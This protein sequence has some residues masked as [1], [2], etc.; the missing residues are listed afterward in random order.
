MRRGAR[1][2]VLTVLTA[3]ALLGGCRR[4]AQPSELHATAQPPLWVISDA[5]GPRA[6]IFGT[7]HALPEGVKWQGPAIDKAVAASDRLVFEIGEELNPTSAQA[8]L[9]RLGF[10]PGLPPPSQRIAPAR[11]ADLLALYR[12]L[13]VDDR[14]FV[15]K[16]SW[17]VALQLAAIASKQEGVTADNGVEP[18]LQAMAKGKP[19]EGLETLDAQFGAFDGLS[20]KDQSALLADVAQETAHGDDQDRDMMLLWLKGD[21][22]GIAE[23]THKGFMAEPGLRAALLTRRTNTWA[24]EID[25]M[26]RRGAHPFVAVGAAH[27]SGA[28]GLPA[29]MAARGYA[30]RRVQ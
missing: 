13:G 29:L 7:V 9:A 8:A 10:T 5:S 20:A 25:A 19:V 30:V 28:D 6:W 3:L 15:N 14:N 18:A 21:T 27:V 22:Q 23:E 26:I 1:L 16:E 24:Q 2:T 11:R 4:H 12:K 17:A